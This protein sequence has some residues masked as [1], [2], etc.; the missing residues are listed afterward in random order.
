MR[1]ELRAAD[2]AATS[3]YGEAAQKLLRQSQE[4]LGDLFGSGGRESLQTGILQ[5]WDQILNVLTWWVQP[6]V[7]LEKQ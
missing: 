6:E 2:T 5:L 7:T 1:K 4:S 3:R